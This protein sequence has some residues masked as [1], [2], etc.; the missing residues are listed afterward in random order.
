MKSMNSLNL[1]SK[2]C[3]LCQRGKW[4][5]IFIT[6]QCNANCHFCP[7]PFKDDSI[8]TAFG[9]RKEEILPY[10]IKHNFEGIS[11]SGGDPFIVFD[12]LLEWFCYFKERLPDY[13]YWV[14]TN[15]LD[16]NTQNLKLLAMAGMDE[17]RFNIAAT[18]YVSETV[19]ERIKAAR[20][21]FPFVT[22]EIPSIK[23]DFHFLEA[24][25][26]IIEKSGVDYLNL[27][28]YILTESDPYSLYE[29]SG[30]FLLNKLSH[31]KYAL[32]SLD[33]TI[34]TQAI[35]MK[36]G[37]H[38][39]INHCSMEQKEAQ[40]TRRRIMMGNVFNDPEYDIVQDDGTICNYY[41]IPDEICSDDLL[42]NMQDPGFRNGFKSYLIKTIDLI[43]TQSSGF[44]TIKVI[45]IPQM[46]INR[47]KI[48]IGINTTTS[49]ST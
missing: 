31:L 37:Y 22:I 5:C 29:P 15:G 43:D 9:N 26:E 21:L 45:Y 34:D 13:Y 32:S 48:M 23:E 47:E 39:R 19:M 11:F 16:A 27:H 44:K 40:M 46:E 8:R 35:A 4:F 20:E 14:Y 38:F 17:I 18:G 41:R 2:G 12:R 36:K 10:L 25:M 30:S 3:Q 1:L 6:Y 33:N 49:D 7:A 42:R 28:D 24:A